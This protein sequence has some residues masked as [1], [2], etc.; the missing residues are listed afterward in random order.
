MKERISHT[1][2]R[3]WH[4][5]LEARG[6]RGGKWEPLD[7]NVIA[8]VDRAWLED[9]VLCDDVAAWRTHMRRIEGEE[10][11]RQRRTAVSIPMDYCRLAEDDT[12]LFL[13]D[14]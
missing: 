2:P 4:E 13:Y 1:F 7:R 10:E 3:M 5:G 12:A 8:L 9:R 6:G 11:G 14:I